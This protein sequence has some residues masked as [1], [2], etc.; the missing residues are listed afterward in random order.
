VPTEKRQ[1]EGTYI[2]VVHGIGEHG[3]LPADEYVS[4]TDV[5]SLDPELA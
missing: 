5:D 2:V 1:D 3:E 4:L